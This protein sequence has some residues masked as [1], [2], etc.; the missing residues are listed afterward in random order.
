M[1]TTVQLPASPSIHPSI[2]SQAGIAASANHVT[3]K[4]GEGDAAVLALDDVSIART[5]RP[6]HRDHGAVRLRQVD[7]AARPG[8][9]RPAD[10]R[11]RSS[12]GTP[13]SPRLKDKAL[14]L[15]RRDRIGFIFQSFNL[16]PTLT[17][18]ENI[19]LPMRIAGRKPDDA[20]GRLDRRDRRPDRAARRTDRRSSPAGSS[21][22]WRQ[23]GRSPRDP[24]SSSPTSRPAPSTPRPAPSCSRSCA[25]RSPTSA[26]PSSW[27]PTTPWPRA[28]PTASSS[29]PTATSSTSFTR[30]PPTQVLDH[31]K[32][33]G[34]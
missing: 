21:S 30:R 2:E 18:A 9:P 4:Y 24:R 10:D 17:A 22:E 25:P 15:L 19:V 3:K 29:S 23:P 27:S 13:R 20:L 16:L 5:G 6:V 32:H 1:H 11:A 7:A 8:R 12:S 34:A 28:T 26:R 33:L 14:T 31:M